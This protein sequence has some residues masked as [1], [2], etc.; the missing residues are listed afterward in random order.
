MIAPITQPLELPHLR[1]ETL[2]WGPGNGR[3]MLCLHGYP[4]TAWTWRHLG[5]FF[6]QRGFRVVAPFMRGYAPTEMARD[7]DYGLGALMFDAIELHRGLDGGSDAVLVGHDWGALAANGIAAYPDSPFTKVVSD[8]RA[9][10]GRPDPQLG[11]HGRV[12]QNNAP[13]TPNELVC[14]LPTTS[15]DL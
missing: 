10:V 9:H 7:G 2:T 3:L 4:D 1:F 15:E 6:A 11:P 13:A 8:G 14:A 12:A 5:P